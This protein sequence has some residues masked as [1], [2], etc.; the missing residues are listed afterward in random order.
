MRDHEVPILQKDDLKTHFE[1]ATNSI[2]K[3]S[4]KILHKKR[5]YLNQVFNFILEDSYM[6]PH[7][8]PGNANILL[9]LDSNHTHDHVLRVHYDGY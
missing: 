8:H 4:P 1:L 9:C 7:L 5:A 3:R 2:R 6:H